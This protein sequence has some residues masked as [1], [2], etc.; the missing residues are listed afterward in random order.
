LVFAGELFTLFATVS[1]AVPGNPIGTGQVTFMDG[2]TVLGTVPESGGT[3]SLEVQLPAGAHT[4]TA[5]YQGDATHSGSTSNPL[6]VAVDQLITSGSTVEAKNPNGSTDFS[7][8]PYGKTGRGGFN[9]AAGQVTLDTAADVFVAP[10]RGH[11]APVKVLDG[12]TGATLHSFFP[13]GRRFSGGI[14]LA[15][16]D[17]N[18]NGRSE[19]IAGRAT[20]RRSQIKVLDPAN[21]QVLHTIQAFDRVFHRGLSLSVGDTNSIRLPNI[22]AT[23]RGRHATLLEVFD[24]RTGAQV[25]GIQRL[26]IGPAGAFTGKRPRR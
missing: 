11:R 25:G 7:V 5:V 4:L 16:A 10:R 8:Q 20:G 23:S 24:G 6:A 9:V 21:G 1:S 18:G 2:S 22:I 15:A 14:A 12:R 26:P 3:A 19:I 13:F 17:L